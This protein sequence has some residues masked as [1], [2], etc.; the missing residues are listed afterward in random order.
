MAKK[1]AKGPPEDAYTRRVM[2]SASKTYFTRKAT[3][4]RTKSTKEWIKTHTAKSKA[5]IPRKQIRLRKNLRHEKKGVA[6]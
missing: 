2:K 1:A 5:Y 4:T 3:E 6:S